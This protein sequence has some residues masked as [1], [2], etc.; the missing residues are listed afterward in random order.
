MVIVQLDKASDTL[1][2]ILRKLSTK[3]SIDLCAD[4][5]KASPGVYPFLFNVTVETMSAKQ[6]FKMLNKYFKTK[7]HLVLPKHIVVNDGNR[8]LY[9]GPKNTR[10]TN[11]ILTRNNLQCT[12]LENTFIVSKLTEAASYTNPFLM[13]G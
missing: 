7:K 4:Q 8:K 5:K 12:D 9:F 11:S 6:P 1:N 2:H 10:P 3:D 13:S